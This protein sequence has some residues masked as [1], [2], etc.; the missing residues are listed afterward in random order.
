MTF[1][2]SRL[3]PAHQ[4][5]HYVGCLNIE[6]VKV[7]HVLVEWWAVGLQSTTSIPVETVVKTTNDPGRESQ[8]DLGTA[9]SPLGIILTDSKLYCES[10]VK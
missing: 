8:T 4:A 3:H 2:T 5:T 1:W 6:P 7:E 9:Y 10:R